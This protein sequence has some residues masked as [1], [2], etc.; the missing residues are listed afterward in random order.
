MQNIT[1]VINTEINLWKELMGNKTIRTTNLISYII[2][3]L[4]LII[5]GIFW[6]QLPPLVPLWYSKPWGNDQLAN[7]SFLFLLPFGSLLWNSVNTLISI[8]FIKDHL[9]FSQI[10]SFTSL[11]ISI[12]SGITLIMIIWVII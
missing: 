1:I 5:I 8:H 4:S 2:L 3:I 10:L 6:K 12:L 7:P 9:V 11:L